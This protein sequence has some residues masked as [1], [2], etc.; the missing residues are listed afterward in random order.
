[1]NETHAFSSAPSQIPE[2]SCKVFFKCM[3]SQRKM[4]DDEPKCWELKSG[5]V[6]GWTVTDLVDLEQNSK[7]A[8]GKGKKPPALHCRTPRRL[9][10]KWH[11]VLLK[12]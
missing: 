7:S 6:D 1:M 11:Q 10:S 2:V 9:G 8:A 4:G 5:W 12:G 3:S